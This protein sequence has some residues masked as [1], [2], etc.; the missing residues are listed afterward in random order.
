MGNGTL[1]RGRDKDASGCHSGTTGDGDAETS[2]LAHGE[3]E[4][5]VG[6]GASLPLTAAVGATT[7][8]GLAELK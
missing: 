6:E 2:S 8:D 4:T 5:S 3:A 7:L 1:A